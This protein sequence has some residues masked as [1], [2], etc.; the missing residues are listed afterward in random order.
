MRESGEHH[1]HLPLH[2][3]ARAVPA[4]PIQRQTFDDHQWRTVGVLCDLIIPA[5]DR[6]GSATQAGV[7]EF[8]DD[9]IAFRKE[10]DGNRE[11]ARRRSSA[12][13][14]GSTANRT[15]SLQ[16]IFA[17]ASPDQQKQILD[18]IAYPERAAKEDHAVGRF[19]NRIPRSHGERIL[20][21]QDGRRRSAVSRQHGRCRVE[22]LRSESV[23]HHR[24]A[25][26]ERLQRRGGSRS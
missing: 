24:R 6:S 22:R 14:C 26:E 2:A 19:F 11:S 9:W 7:P 3:A 4:G 1:A 18:R 16:K 13:S 21:E 25:H 8:I 23:G 15:R 10:Q 20:F 12:A 5:D 17:D